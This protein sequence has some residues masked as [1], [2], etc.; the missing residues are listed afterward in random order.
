MLDTSSRRA[1]L[2]TGAS[3]GIGRAC[4]LELARLGFDVFAGV[5][6]EE[7]G[8]AVEADAG[9]ITGPCGKVSAVRVE[10]TDAGSIHAAIAQITDATGDDGLCGVV[11]NAGIS[12]VGPVEFVP[13]ADWRRQFEINF[14]GVI[15]VTQAALPLLRKHVVKNG[16]WSARLVNMSSI[17]GRIAQPILGPYTASKHALESLSDS[18]R[19]ELR[20]QGIHVCSVNP[21]AID[22][23]IWNKA[24]A[25]VNTV[26]MDHPSRAIYGNLIDGVTAAASR[27]HAGAIQPC[28]VAKAVAS[29]LTDG[30]PRTRY[31]VGK[32]AKSGALAKRLIPDRM[33]DSILEKYFAVRK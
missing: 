23:P 14:F 29:S 1:V 7:D 17:A 19:I 3:T 12:V 33:F 16:K 5:R 31:F 15:A 26:P 25:E 32:D 24:Q 2:I 11:N 22:T 18:L 8:R 30:K 20:P 13:L 10:V 28:E 27:A 6:R 21:G 9:N 4:T